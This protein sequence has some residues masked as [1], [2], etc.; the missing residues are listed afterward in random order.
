MNTE[1]IKSQKYKKILCNCI[2]IN[3]KKIK[4]PNY[5]DIRDIL[6]ERVIYNNKGEVILNEFSIDYGI[7]LKTEFIFFI[8]D[9]FIGIF[10]NKYIVSMNESDLSFIFSGTTESNWLEESFG[11]GFRFSDLFMQKCLKEFEIPIKKFDRSFINDEFIYS[12]SY[13]KQKLV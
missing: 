2:N 5:S 13:K 11:W 10:D 4:L 8:D 7:F 9:V 1:I 6:L 12:V 3:E